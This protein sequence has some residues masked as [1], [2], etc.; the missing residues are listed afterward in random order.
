MRDKIGK[1]PLVSGDKNYWI[2]FSRDRKCTVCG[3]ICRGEGRFICLSGGALKGDDRFAEMSA[4]LIGFLHLSLH[5]HNYRGKGGY[6]PIADNTKNG[7][8]EFYFCS[9]R[10]IRKFLKEVVDRFEEGMK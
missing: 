5:D 2:P 6:F 4:G 1:F 9:C 7:Q 8:F 10:C 3:K